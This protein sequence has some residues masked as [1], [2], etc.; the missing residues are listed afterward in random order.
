MLKKLIIKLHEINAVKFGE[1][2]LKSGIMSPIYIDLRVTI[3]Y[4]EVLKMVAEAMW[5]K[6]KDVNFDLICGV[7]YTALPIATAIS[8]AHD[9]PMIMR[10]K[11]VKDYGTKKAIEGAFV[12][13]QKVLVV[14]DLV[15]SG[16]SVFETIEPLQH[17][18]LTVSDIVVLVDREQGG[19]KHLA[20]KGFN[21]HSVL[22]I[23]E[24]LAVLVEASKLDNAM[25]DKVKDFINANQ[26]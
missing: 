9:K 5:E 6:V 12:A 17:E 16:S 10:R 11:E 23:S 24:M 21:L 8:L 4:P 22:T 2:K 13:G 15:T 3:S 7:P 19:R 1:F 26:V 18:G 25:A 20:E 14:E